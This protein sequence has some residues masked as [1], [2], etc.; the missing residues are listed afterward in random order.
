MILYGCSGTHAQNQ[1]L[2]YESGRIRNPRSASVT[3]RVQ[4]QAGL[5]DN[6]LPHKNVGAEEIAQWLHMGSVEFSAPM[7][8]SWQLPVTPLSE[9]LMPSPSLHTGGWGKK[10]GK[11]W[12]GSPGSGSL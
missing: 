6:N 10:P 11:P 2:D 8:S 9:D 7:S 5:P 12:L 3:Y 4:G 1:P